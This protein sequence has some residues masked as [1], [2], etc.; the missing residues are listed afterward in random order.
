MMMGSVFVTPVQ[1][2][3]EILGIHIL[4]PA[5]LGKADALLENGDDKDKFVTVPFTLADLD[6]K[7]E[8]KTFFAECHRLKIRPIVRLTTRFE[9]GNWAVP[10]RANIVT[11]A[12]FLSGLEWHRPELTII[13]FNE[14]NH[15]KEWGGTIDPTSFASI[16][17]FTADWFKTESKT[18]TVL[19]AAMDLA[20]DGHN[21]TK[22]AF[23]YWQEALA[24]EPTLLDK[25]D[26]WNSHSY[27]NPAFASSPNRTDKMSLRGYEHELVFIK[28]YTQKEFPVYITETGWNQQAL[29][30]T[31][32]RAYFKQAYEQIWQKDERIVA[33]TPFLLQGAPGTFAPFSFLDKNGNPTVAYDTYRA[34]LQANN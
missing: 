9:S 30:N 5:E 13:A 8:W 15:A 24:H 25:F 27:P 2:R 29:T 6:K 23:A 21:G 1:A 16:S 11:M 34:L 31:R 12:R 10:T 22:E 17:A 14:P 33:V 20:A 32:F 3:G 7:E 4:N 19:P 26:G 28:K 18:Y